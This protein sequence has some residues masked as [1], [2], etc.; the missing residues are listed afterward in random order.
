MVG[1]WG[2][3]VSEKERKVGMFSSWLPDLAW[4]ASIWASIVWKLANFRYI[5]KPNSKFLTSYINEPIQSFNFLVQSGQNGLD[6]LRTGEV[7][8]FWVGLAY[9]RLATSVSRENCRTHAS[10]YPP[11][12]AHHHPSFTSCQLGGRQVKLHPAQKL[13]SLGISFVSGFDSIVSSAA[14]K[15]WSRSCFKRICRI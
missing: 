13:Y 3:L 12:S 14:W 15:Y 10:S 8:A 2:G 11:T 7:K 4:L 1:Y 6:W 9:W 5:W